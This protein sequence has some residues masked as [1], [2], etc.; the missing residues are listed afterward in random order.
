MANQVKLGEPCTRC[1]YQDQPGP[2]LSDAPKDGMIYFFVGEGPGKDEIDR[3]RGFVGAA[4]RELFTLAEAAGISRSEVRCGNVVKCLPVG[5]EYGKYSLDPEAIKC[6]SS[7]LEEELRE[8][9]GMIV[10]VGGV[11]AKVIAQLEPIR[12]WRGVIV[13]RPLSLG[14]LRSS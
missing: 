7:Y 2:V 4:G 3:G 11:A 12:R 13:R 10:P 5:A 9:S 1:P 8:W 14:K 6:C